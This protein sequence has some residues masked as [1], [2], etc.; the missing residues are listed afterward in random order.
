[1]LREK[2]FEHHRRHK[3][4]VVMDQGCGNLFQTI[5]SPFHSI[6]R[7]EQFQELTGCV[8][9]SEKLINGSSLLSST[10]VE[11]LVENL[12][13]AHS[14]FKDVLQPTVDTCYGDM[15]ETQM[16]GLEAYN[17]QALEKA[18]GGHSSSPAASFILGEIFDGHLYK[19]CV[20]LIQSLI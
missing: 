18:D 20:C 1:M 10:V 15:T 19:F 3:T 12:D 4:T 6:H 9:A 14:Q 13:D 16:R 8:M 11:Y 7:N 2:G 5:H 17:A